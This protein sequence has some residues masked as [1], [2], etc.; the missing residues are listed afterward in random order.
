MWLR[1]VLW[2]GITIYFQ[3]LWRHNKVFANFDL[4]SLFVCVPTTNVSWAD[5]W[6]GDDDNCQNCGEN[7]DNN[8]TTM[9][10]FQCKTTKTM[11]FT[12]SSTTTAI[13][14]AATKTM[15]MSTTKTAHQL[16]R[17][18]GELS[19][20]RPANLCKQTSVNPGIVFLCNLCMWIYLCLLLYMCVCP[21]VVFLCVCDFICLCNFVYVIVFLSLLLCPFFLWSPPLLHLQSQAGE[22]GEPLG[23]PS[24]CAP[25]R[26]SGKII[27][28]KSNQKIF[29]ID[30]WNLQWLYRLNQR[31]WKVILQ[32][33][34]PKIFKITMCWF[35]DMWH[36]DKLTVQKFC[37]CCN[38]ALTRSFF[39]GWR[40]IYKYTYMCPIFDRWCY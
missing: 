38:L 19:P 37:C 32:T 40:F 6:F 5:T 12:T 17:A 25:I 1:L 23:P 16:Q 29:N 4:C 15:A 34:K 2:H 27:L 28:K 11:A 36:F 26:G 7:D 21:V 3:I 33:L 35:Q 31:L 20:L 22:P 13:T 24:L 39:C 18:W 14:T 30:F 8:N 9:I 10:I